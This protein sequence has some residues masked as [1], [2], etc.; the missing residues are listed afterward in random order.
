MNPYRSATSRRHPRLRSGTVGTLVGIV[1]ISGAAL[2]A[3]SGRGAIAS[4]EA[5]YGPTNTAPPTVSGT[6]EEGQ[7]L[8]ASPGTWSGTGIKFG[9]AWRRCSAS[10]GSCAD[11]SGA[12]AQTYKLQ[13]VDVGNTLRVRVTAT[14]SSGSSSATSVPT[15]V[16]K[17]TP[18]PPM[19]GCPSGTNTAAVTQ[20]STPARLSI[21]KFAVSPSPV[22]R[23]TE[24]I[25][26]RFHVAD[27]CGQSVSGAL[28]YV[29]A[30]PYNQF[31][32]PPEQATS[33]DGWVELRM[34]RQGGYPAARRQQLLVFLVRARKPGEN[35]LAGI[36]TRRLVSVSVNLAL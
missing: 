17:A 29:T 16:V 1:V 22:G 21:D 26:A 11:I 6:P 18:K 15:A 14:T 10:G 8:K 20:V 36:S 34:N 2:A 13:G 31:S 35:V 23:S 12:V 19:T 27:T 32:I 3:L 28:V 25:A 33:A 5:Q 7:T 24:A 4:A 30:V 9:Y